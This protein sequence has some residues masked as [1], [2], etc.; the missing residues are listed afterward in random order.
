VLCAG[1][2]GVVY[3]CNP[4]L[5]AGFYTWTLPA[6]ATI[7]SGAGTRNI[8]VDFGTTATGGNISVAGN[9]SCGN[10]VVSPEFNVTVNS[11]PAIPVITVSGAVLT[12]S[13]ASG[14]QWYFEGPLIPGATGQSYTVSNN[15]GFYWCMVTVN[16][17][18]SAASNKVWVVANAVDDKLKE[19]I[20]VY[21][22]PNNGQFTV[23]ISSHTEE[24]WSIEVYDQAGVR[25]YKINDLV[26]SG[27][28]EKQIDLQTAVGGLY[29]VA[30]INNNQKIIKK[31]IISR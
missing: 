12:S 10:G 24:S 15:T 22:S 2:N 30:F 31:I 29:T 25:I 16:G 20:A 9:N 23:R 26:V 4:I 17:C 18:S 6:G 8:T 7:S 27:F 19:G 1:T 11:I 13:A 3:S 21:P 5:N 28:L 14:N